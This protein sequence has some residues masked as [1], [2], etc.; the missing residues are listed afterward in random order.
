MR[1]LPKSNV[2]SEHFDDDMDDEGSA[3]PFQI[4]SIEQGGTLQHDI[5]LSSPIEQ[6]AAYDALSQLLRQSNAKAV[7]NMYINTPGGDLLAGLSLIQAMRDCKANITTILNPQ[8]FSMGA[9]LFL[10]GDVRVA[11]AHSLLMFHHY[12]GGLFGKGNEQVAELA[13]TSTWFEH[14]MQDICFP[15]LDKK[16]IRNMLQGKDI[17]LQHSD[18]Q[19][20]LIRV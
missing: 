3:P 7:I 6:P 11:P 4:F 1:R 19:K 13:A 8:A 20:R 12:S 9:V 10:C 14:V 17:W 16:E 18:I 5:Y 2:S 15:F